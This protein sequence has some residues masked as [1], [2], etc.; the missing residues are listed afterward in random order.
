MPSKQTTSEILDTLLG[1]WGASPAFEEDQINKAL[2]ALHQALVDKMP[3]KPKQTK[4][5]REKIDYINREYIDGETNGRI[6]AL[7]EMQQVIDDFF[8]VDS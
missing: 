6:K 5:N 4:K 7:A 2:Q 8:G 1:E 3:K